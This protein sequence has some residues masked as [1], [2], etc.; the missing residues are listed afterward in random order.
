VS[1]DGGPGARDLVSPFLGVAAIVMSLWFKIVIVGLGGAVGALGRTGL[2]ALVA[3]L[4]PTGGMP[5]GEMFGTMAVNIL[6]C[7]LMGMA[8]AGVETVGWGSAETNA[9][10]LS[11]CLGAFTT[12]STFEAE[13]AALWRN[14]EALGAALYLGGSVLGGMIAFW[15][16]WSL[17]AGGAGR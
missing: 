13:T 1:V 14:R 12:F 4:F 11:G 15:L 7:F 16:G 6:G 8:K 5:T 9:F 3:S 17:V 10:L 2:T